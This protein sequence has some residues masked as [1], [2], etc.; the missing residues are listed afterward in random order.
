M[1]IYGWRQYIQVLGVLHL[2]CGQCGNSAEQVL[3]KLT[4][5]FTLFWIP[6]FPINKKHTLTCTV[7]ESEQKV[8]G[9]QAQQLL[10][11]G[12]MPGMPAPGMPGMPAPAMAA[13]G[14][15]GGPGTQPPGRP[16]PAM[17]AP[18]HYGP[19]QRTFG[20]G[21]QGRHGPPRPGFGSPAGPNGPS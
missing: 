3:R 6:L 20:P 19:P 16:A 2:V 1:I 11:T 8:P 9:A 13:P 5:K 14:M 17:A 4:T 7:C 18:Q 12:G 10:A 21:P 15:P